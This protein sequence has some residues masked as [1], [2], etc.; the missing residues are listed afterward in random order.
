M[1]NTKGEVKALLTEV[2][3]QIKQ[4]DEARMTPKSEFD[5]WMRDKSD[6]ADKIRGI[7]APIVSYWTAVENL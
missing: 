4:N 3:G 5:Y 7:I 2:Q 1:P 6:E